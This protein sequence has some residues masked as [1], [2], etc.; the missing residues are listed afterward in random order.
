MSSIFL[1]VRTTTE[2]IQNNRNIFDIVTGS[3]EIYFYYVNKH[4]L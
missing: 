3:H 1:D 4:I 2:H